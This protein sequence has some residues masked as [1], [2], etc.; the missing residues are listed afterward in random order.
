MCCDDDDAPNAMIRS[1]RACLGLVF[2]LAL[3]AI[4][5]VSTPAQT[6][7]A[8][9][10]LSPNS[11]YPLRPGLA[12]SYDVES[13]DGDSVLATA[14]V[15]R[16][17]AGTVEVQSGQATLRYRLQPDGIAR[18]EPAGYLLKAP[19]AQGAHWASGPD[20]T[21]RVT[22]LQERLTTPAGSFE[23]CVVV[24]EQNARSGQTVT[25]TYCPG[26]GPV[27]VISQMSVRGRTLQVRALLRGF[28]SD[29]P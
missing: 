7:R 14:R 24:E 18:I 29:S 5:C 11:L 3:G 17:E 4:A 9:V 19:I 25:T 26:T 2:G 13:G 1:M 23:A 15:L 22:S 8:T 21:A 27:R 28:G 12:W 16:A 10:D 20:T 6:A